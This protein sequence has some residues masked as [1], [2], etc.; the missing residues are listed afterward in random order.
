MTYR[1]SIPGPKPPSGP[2]A[3]SCPQQ[4]VS[5][6]A[7]PRVEKPESSDGIRSLGSSKVTDRIEAAVNKP[8]EQLFHE[9]VAVANV[10]VQ[11]SHTV[12][13]L[14]VNLLAAMAFLAAS[15][16]S[17]IAALLLGPARVWSWCYGL[18]YGSLGTA[19][20]AFLLA[21]FLMFMLLTVLLVWFAYRL[22]V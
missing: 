22:I 8:T 15:P 3:A 5:K 16:W 19:A 4:G 9:A 10:A 21:A 20:I 11:S 1:S 14:G 17:W 13:G 12:G 6:D 2:K 18:V 7:S